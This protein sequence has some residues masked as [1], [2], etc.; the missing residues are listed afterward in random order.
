MIEL[1]SELRRTGHPTFIFSNTNE[2]AIDHVRK[3]FPFFSEF[4]GY[5]L[6]YQHY[7]MKPDAGL[8]EAVEKLSGCSGAEI[9]YLDD[10]Q[11]NVVA[12]AKRDWRTIHHLDPQQTRSQVKNLGLLH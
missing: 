10:R 2:L 5:I 7:C 12:G 4:R 6:S 1:H 3:V 9:L 8:Y 11:E